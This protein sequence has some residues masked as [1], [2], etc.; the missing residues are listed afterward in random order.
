M[1]VAGQARCLRDP[2]KLHGGLEYRTGVELSGQVAVNLLPRSLGRR[3]TIPTV[4]FKFA[5]ASRE[6]FGGYEHV[7]FAPPQIHTHP[8]AG[9]QQSKPAADRSFGRSIENRRRSGG[10]GLAP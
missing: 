4:R 6:F 3:H 7:H 9:A 10:S 2:L 1:T 5:T 8:I